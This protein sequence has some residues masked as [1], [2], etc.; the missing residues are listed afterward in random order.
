ML[1]DGLYLSIAGVDGG[2]AAAVSNIPVYAK[3]NK[4]NRQP[5][6]GANR[7]PDKGVNNSGYEDAPVA[8]PCNSGY[9]EATLSP[10]RGID[11]DSKPPATPPR[12]HSAARM[13]TPGDGYED[14]FVTSSSGYEENVVT[15]QTKESVKYDHLK[16]KVELDGI[17]TKTGLEAPDGYGQVR[18]NSGLVD[19]E[20]YQHLTHDK[21][22]VDTEQGYG[23]LKRDLKS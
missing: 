17:D 14:N 10:F 5:V 22:T 12:P 2:I 13:S 7:Q 1:L 11:D 21:K 8:K 6:N 9:E 16:R 23:K 20:E 4:G 15:P 3:P 19:S 18:P